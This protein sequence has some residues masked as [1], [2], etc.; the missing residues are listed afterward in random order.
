MVLPLLAAAAA[1]ASLAV[2]ALM[3]GNWAWWRGW[4]A[5]RL[6][7]RAHSWEVGTAGD[8]Y[9]R[10]LDDCLRVLGEDHPHIRIVR[11]NLAH[12]QGQVGE[13]SQG[14]ETRRPI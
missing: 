4:G 11:H 7:R 8:A 6:S 13:D 10:L 1:V 14:V 12:W 9:E 2:G 5:R 3:N